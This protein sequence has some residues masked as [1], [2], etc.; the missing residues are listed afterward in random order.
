MQCPAS[1]LFLEP[2]RFG[3]FGAVKCSTSC[4]LPQIVMLQ[5]A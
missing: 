3:P 1:I 2:L 5:F 4:A